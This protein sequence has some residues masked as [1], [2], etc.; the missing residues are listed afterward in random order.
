MGDMLVENVSSTSV[1][2][3]EDKVVAVCTLEEA[4]D[5]PLAQTKEGPSTP[6][7]PPGKLIQIQVV[8]RNR[9]FKL[10]IDGVEVTQRSMDDSVR[11]T[12]HR[13]LN[14]DT[15]SG[16][17]VFSPCAVSVLCEDGERLP[18]RCSLK[19]LQTTIGTAG[20]LVGE[21]ILLDQAEI[22][23]TPLTDFN[24]YVTIAP[25][26]LTFGRPPRVVIRDLTALYNYEF[27][28]MDRAILKFLPIIGN[29][30][31]A[32]VTSGTELIQ[33]VGLPESKDRLA[34]AA[35]FASS[36]TTAAAMSGLGL[37]TVGFML[38]G[39]PV[40]AGVLMGAIQTDGTLLG[41]S[42]IMPWLGVVAQ[43]LYNVLSSRPAPE[44]IDVAMTLSELAETLDS[45]GALTSVR[46]DND[47]ANVAQS[48]SFRREILVWR[49]FM[50]DES[51]GKL[52]NVKKDGMFTSNPMI[53]DQFVVGERATVGITLRVEVD[54]SEHCIPNKPLAWDVT[55]EREDRTFLGALASGTLDDLAK[56]RRSIERFRDKMDK[57]I[58]DAGGKQWYTSLAKG[59]WWDVFFF[60][61]VM[62]FGQRQLKYFKG[63]KTT[64]PLTDLGMQ[65]KRILELVRNSLEEK[66]V[67]KFVTGQNLTVAGLEAKLTQSANDSIDGP[68]MNTGGITVHRFLP[69]RASGHM[70]F[71]FPG[72]RDASSEFLDTIS[73]E[74]VVRE[75]SALHDARRM[76]QTVTQSSLAA[77]KSLL[78]EWESGSETRCQF[79]HVLKYETM[80]SIDDL[81][82]TIPKRPNDGYALVLQQPDDVREACFTDTLTERE[83]KQLDL[84]TKRHNVR[85]F[86]RPQTLLDNVKIPN[87]ESAFVAMHVFGE[88][89]VDEI[90]SVLKRKDFERVEVVQSSVHR[91]ASRLLQCANF[92]YANTKR[93]DAGFLQ[94]GDVAFLATRA[95]RDSHRLRR[96]MHLPPR[97]EDTHRRSVVSVRELKDITGAL[98]K[99]ASVVSGSP[100]AVFAFPSEPLQSLLGD[101]LDGQRAFKRI[102]AC[103]D[104]SNIPVRL[105]NVIVGAVASSFP[106]NG[107]LGIIRQPEPAVE[108]L[109]IRDPIVDNDN[110]KKRRNL[111]TRLAELRVDLVGLPVSMSPQTVSQLTD[112]MVHMNVTHAKPTVFY[113]PH[114]FGDSPPP[115]IY[116]STTSPMFGSVPVRLSTVIELIRTAVFVEPVPAPPAG[117]PQSHTIRF[118]TWPCNDDMKV[119]PLFIERFNSK[120]TTVFASM[121]SAPEL[122]DPAVGNDDVASYEAAGVDIGDVAR[123]FLLSDTSRHLSHRVA[124]MAWNAERVLQAACMAS[125]SYDG[126][127]MKFVIDL[128]NLTEKVPVEAPR[129]Q[130]SAETKQQLQRT[131]RMF[132]SGHYAMLRSIVASVISFGMFS[133]PP[134]L[135]ERAEDEQAGIQAFSFGA[136]FDFSADQLSKI[137]SLQENQ[138]LDDNDLDKWI[139]NIDE[140]EKEI[141]DAIPKVGWQSILPPFKLIVDEKYRENFQRFDWKQSTTI[142]VIKSFDAELQKKV[143]DEFKL[144]QK[145]DLG[146]IKALREATTSSQARYSKHVNSKV[147]LPLLAKKRQD[148]FEAST[149]R[150]RSDLAMASAIG[151]S[152]ASESLGIKG[153]E[154]SIVWRATDKDHNLLKARA[155][156]LFKVLEP[157]EPVVQALS[158]AQLC[159]LVAGS[160]DPVKKG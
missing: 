104:G 150:A 113:V 79:V 40:S 24:S 1:L 28:R 130:V 37:L 16:N 125:E 30:L 83:R 39:S 114:G 9:K 137:A 61:K 70:T 56:L 156:N 141:L 43:S 35:K 106:S 20:Q 127:P 15:K 151:I 128:A 154:F 67:R 103:V 152:M 124:S 140:Y 60:G 95:G 144:S 32:V 58:V 133:I 155:E 97:D 90:T 136:R 88:L 21:P 153:S 160:H 158:L 45:L 145:Y 132:A 59:D 87:T 19:V 122:V 148:E 14:W 134:V 139:E 65:R 3:I 54:D 64:K 4:G 66:L 18:N 77:L 2:K 69:H 119:H 159:C 7:A 62:R 44:P 86:T 38:M 78:D 47:L 131:A 116:P 109:P 157:A 68:A 111:L 110:E 75:F 129:L 76:M 13:G 146:Y 85:M 49:W 121:M 100:Q 51:G 73:S 10:L 33:T 92:I 138:T 8:K 5:P 120:T 117:T 34:A 55:C 105:R 23:T 72:P 57:A 36:Q 25:Y 48:Q 74:L 27:R 12:H 11:I 98:R 147:K 107:L 135:D 82:E 123:G 108:L 50:E 93:E 143:Y 112:A 96:R 41:L 94:D 31:M 115:L 22:K 80:E 99:V 6:P 63:S 118:K 26:P 46:D 102:K 91:A 52:D 71:L 101:A 29:S 81:N 149:Q 17:R 84:I 126:N 53:L 142:P 89:L 42:S